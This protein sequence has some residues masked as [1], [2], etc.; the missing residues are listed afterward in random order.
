MTTIRRNDLAPRVEMLPL[1][2]VLF[3]LLTF[4]IY[5]WLTMWQAEILPV[6]LV[7]LPKG[8][9]TPGRTVSAITLDAKGRIFWNRDLVDGVE[10]DER[11]AALA[12]DPAQPT[13]YLAIEEAGEV[14]RAPMVPRLIQRIMKAGVKNFAFVGPPDESGEA[15]RPE[16]DAEASAD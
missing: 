4:F 5:S 16:T 8:D 9:Q 12:R 14:D 13:L 11:L 15:S 7:T 1:I 3:L 2:D 6:A 10:L